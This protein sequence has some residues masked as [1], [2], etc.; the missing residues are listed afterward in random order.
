MVRGSNPDGDKVFIWPNSRYFC[1]F[2]NSPFQA[3]YEYKDSNFGGK[4][5]L[6]Q[7]ILPISSSRYIL[8]VKVQ[9][10]KMDFNTGGS[11]W[12]Q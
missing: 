11:W 1:L 9:N 5:Y 7:L 4:D 10:M 3:E 2:V 8:G 6:L 12:W